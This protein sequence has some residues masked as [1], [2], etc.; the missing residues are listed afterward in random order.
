M[1]NFYQLND[2]VRVSVEF[3]STLT[4]APEDPTDVQ[5]YISSPDNV[6]DQ[7]VTWSGSQV[8]RDGVGLFHYDI[9]VQLVGRWHYAFVA[10]GAVEA[11][12]GDVPFVVRPSL[13]VG[14]TIP[15]SA[16]LGAAALV[17]PVAY[18]LVTGSGQISGG[19]QG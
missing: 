9:L 19:G 16:S 3:T 4:G 12:S 13:L 5:L 17:D 10:I 2:L 14:Q 18:E 11:N 15:A 1:T 7:Y 8:V 6:A